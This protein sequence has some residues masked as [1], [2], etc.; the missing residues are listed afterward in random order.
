MRINS[1]RLLSLD[2]S[3]TWWRRGVGWVLVSTTRCVGNL[4]AAMM[5]GVPKALAKIPLG[6]KEESEERLRDESLQV[7]WILVLSQHL[8][9]VTAAKP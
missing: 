7:I 6:E 4:N 8:P 5:S 3:P 2:F 1:R 9:H